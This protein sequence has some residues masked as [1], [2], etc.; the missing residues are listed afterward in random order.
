[1]GD[2]PTS[3]YPVPSR[4]DMLLSLGV[5]CLPHPWVLTIRCRCGREREAPLAAVARVG[6]GEHEARTLGD[7]VRRLRCQ[8]CGRRPISVVASHN[9]SWEG[10]ELL[11]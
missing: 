11:A 10:D 1:M 5:R 3:K 2:Y 8:E 6:L 7:V 4:R 9:P